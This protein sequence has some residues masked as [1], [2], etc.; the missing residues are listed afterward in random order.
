MIDPTRGPPLKRTG[1]HLKRIIPLL[2]NNKSAGTVE[3]EAST[4]SSTYRDYGLRTHARG[5][6]VLPQVVPYT[7]TKDAH[8]SSHDIEYRYTQV[9]VRAGA[10]GVWRWV[11]VGC[12]RDAPAGASAVF[13]AV[14][15]LSIY[16]SIYLS[17]LGS[18][19]TEPTYACYDGSRGTYIRPHQPLSAYC[20]S[21]ARPP[22]RVSTP[23]LSPAPG[24]PVLC[25]LS[26][27]DH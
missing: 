21:R 4:P 5:F 22:T 10:V 12:S 17:P 15:Y 24:R 13:R 3:L 20:V 8:I 19:A 14:L 9:C 16:L 27:A 23:A 11:V 18:D 7:C 6:C 1:R 25:A 2:Y 26:R